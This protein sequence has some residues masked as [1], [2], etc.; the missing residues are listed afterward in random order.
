MS[1][2]CID[3]IIKNIDKSNFCFVIN[4]GNAHGMEK[5]V[6]AGV[7]FAVRQG[8][9][10]VDAFTKEMITRMISEFADMQKQEVAIISRC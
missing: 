3:F 10:D 6:M 2:I 9:N 1:N 5:L 7:F 4:F 8:F